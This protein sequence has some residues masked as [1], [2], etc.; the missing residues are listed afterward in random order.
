MYLFA[1]SYVPVAVRQQQQQQQQQPVMDSALV[2]R[3]CSV[4]T[5]AHRAYDREAVHQNAQTKTVA[6]GQYDRKIRCRL[7]WIRM[8]LF[9]TSLSSFVGHY[10]STDGRRGCLSPLAE[11]ALA[12][13]KAK[14]GQRPP[15]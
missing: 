14:V 5:D 12:K 7:Y 11:C 2:S 13:S 10:T 8:L 4:S 3:K 15:P 9:S 6:R 1:I